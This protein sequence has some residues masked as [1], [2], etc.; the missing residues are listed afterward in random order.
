MRSRSDTFGEESKIEQQ[1]IKNSLRNFYN[2]DLQKVTLHVQLQD[3]SKPKSDTNKTVI[4]GQTI[5]MF[6]RM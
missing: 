1:I 2:L 5:L 3:P 6:N 4:K